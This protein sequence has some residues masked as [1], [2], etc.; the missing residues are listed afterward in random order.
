[1]KREEIENKV[2]ETLTDVLGVE[3]E[4]IKE[5]ARLEDDLNCDSLDCVEIIMEL[6]HELYVNIPD[7]RADKCVT[8][9]DVYDMVEELV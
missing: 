2:N 7:E 4:E 5:G 6:E 8:V 1:M 9:K 3:Q